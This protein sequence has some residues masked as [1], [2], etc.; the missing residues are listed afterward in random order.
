MV[1]WYFLLVIFPHNFGWYSLAL[2]QHVST[3]EH[4]ETLISE[5]DQKI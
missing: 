2:K 4:L 1:V 5:R 3:L